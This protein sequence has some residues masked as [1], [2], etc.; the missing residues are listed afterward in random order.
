M[1]QVHLQAPNMKT[2]II[3][4]P[5]DYIIGVDIRTQVHAMVIILMEANIP[6]RTAFM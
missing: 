3:L 4:L 1:D 6:T 2:T 5:D